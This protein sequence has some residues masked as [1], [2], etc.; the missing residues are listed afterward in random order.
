M[1]DMDFSPPLSEDAT[2]NDCITRMIT[3]IEPYYENFDIEVS[4]L[5]LFYD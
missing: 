3:K 4:R 5:A 1:K 2:L